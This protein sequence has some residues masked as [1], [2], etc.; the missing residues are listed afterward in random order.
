MNVQDQPHV[1]TTER[2]SLV[3]IRR[4]T[5][6]GP[7][8]ERR[9]D[10]PV[11]YQGFDG[12]YINGS[13]RPGRHGGVQIDTVSMRSA[14]SPQKRLYPKTLTVFLD[15]SPS[16]KDRAVHAAALAQRWDA[17]VIGVHVVFAGVRLDPPSESWAIGE[18]AFQA[19]IAH[20]KRLRADAEAVA[21]HVSEHFQALCTRW[22]VAGELRRIDGHRPAQEAILNAL[23]SD[24]VIVGHPEPNGLPDDLTLETI[25]LASGAPLLVLPNAWLGEAIG[26]NVVIGWN[27]SRKARRAIS[28]AMP[29]LVDAQA[30]TTLVVDPSRGRRHG[31]EPGADIALQLARHGVHLDVERVM[32]NGCPIAEVILARAVRIGSDLLVFGAYGHSWLR[33]LL[34]GGTTRTLLA[35]M[36]VPVFVSI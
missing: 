34:L 26:N 23:H 9:A 12:Q 17:H 18:R 32:S 35:Q 20:E 29:F 10:A 7:V 14:P 13:W 28:D 1:K 31:E 6:D 19:V 25:L 2:R 21:A 4:P 22:N 15:A 3:S 27:A 8:T 30:V 36:P 16:G 33:E 5:Q 24:L 11:P